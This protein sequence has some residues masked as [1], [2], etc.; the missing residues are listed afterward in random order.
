MEILK[1]RV[2]PLRPMKHI[3]YST[4]HDSHSETS[5]LCKGLFNWKFHQGNRLC[6]Q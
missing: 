4:C 5:K 1:S 3:C 6:R 2:Y